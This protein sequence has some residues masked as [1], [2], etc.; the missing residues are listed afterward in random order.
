VDRPASRGVPLDAVEK[1]QEFLVSLALHVLAE[2]RAVASL[3]F[4][5]TKSTE[6]PILAKVDCFLHPSVRAAEVDFVLI[7]LSPLYP[8]YSIDPRAVWKGQLALLIALATAVA[9][10]LIPLSSGSRGLQWLKRCGLVAVLLMGAIEIFLLLRYLLYPSY[11]NHAEAMVVA[12]S[13]LGWEG[14]PLYPG[15]DGGNVYGAQYGPFLFQIIGFFLWLFGPSIGAS[16]IPGYTAFALSQVMSFATLRRAGA[17]AGEALAMTAVQCVV[18]AGFTDQGFVF[19]ARSDALLFLAAQTAVFAGTSAP[20][21]PMAAVLGLIGGLVA[22]LKLHGALYVLP[23]F[24]YLFCRSTAAA[25]RLTAVAGFAG[26]VA[27]VVPFTPSNVSLLEYYH[28]FRALSRTPWDRWLFAQNAVFAAM[29]LAPLLLMYIIFTPRL[30]RAFYWFAAALTSCMAIVSI[31]AAERGAGPYHLLPFLPS[32]L[33]G[34]FIIRREVA[35]ELRDPQARGKFE[36]LLL[37]L[38]IALLFGYSPIVISSWSTVLCIF[39]DT[40]SVIE[41]IGEIDRALDDNPSLKI[42]VGPGA[43]AFAAENLR[44]IPVFRGNPLPIDSS[45]W[46]ALEQVGVNDEIIKLAIRECGIDLWLLPS[47]APFVTISHFNGQNIY[48]TEVRA[49]FQAAYVKEISGRVFDQWTC[50]RLVDAPAKRG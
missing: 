31:P 32:I 17:G 46:M 3:L 49:A 13:W 12:T 40:S 35:A 29:C 44:V 9:V 22:N 15:P 23:M 8:L 41:G 2:G 11:L 36:G 26:I 6:P 38:I 16:K 18:L 20:T 50:K 30:P 5:W 39:G 48:S 24:V 7:D 14:Y 1:E 33:W 34:F 21:L 4:V 10:T 25:L 27:L 45:S 28:Y 19:G 42:A 37:G 47:G 43:E